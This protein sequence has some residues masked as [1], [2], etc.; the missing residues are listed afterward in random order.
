MHSGANQVKPVCGI[1][2]CK[3]VET[4]KTSMKGRNYRLQMVCKFKKEK[5]RK[6]CTVETNA[7]VGQLLLKLYKLI[8]VLCSLK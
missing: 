2:L 5:K 1:I 4:T 7:S 8:I 3:E 6:H